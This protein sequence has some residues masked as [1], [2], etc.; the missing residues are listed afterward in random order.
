TA[1]PS[2]AAPR[3]SARRAARRRPRRLAPRPRLLPLPGLEVGLDL[4]VGELEVREEVVA[5]RPALAEE[6][7]EV[8]AL[9]EPGPERLLRVEDLADV[10]L[11]L[12]ELLLR[13]VQHGLA[14]D[15]LLEVR[16]R[17]RV[18]REHDAGDLRRE[19]G[20]EVVAA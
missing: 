1:S 6:A 12:R 10:D 9:E 13:Q 16:R 2:R 8:H 11:D 19:L 15:R 5:L 7:G 17:E 4:V 20:E 14:G 18:R 3:A